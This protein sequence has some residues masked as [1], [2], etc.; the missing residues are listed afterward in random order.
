MIGNHQTESGDYKQED[1]CKKI[2]RHKMP[3]RKNA[4]EQPC[5]KETYRKHNETYQ[6]IRYQFGKN[7]RQFGDR[8]YIDLLDSAHLFLAYYIE[9][10]E[11]TA[12]HC[13]QHHHQCRNH[14]ELV[15]QVRV[16]QILR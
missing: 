5:Q 10:R 16:I 7:K 6:P 11:K 2:Y 1:H 3:H 4:I 8:R 13:Q 14:K 15:V 12:N 9:R